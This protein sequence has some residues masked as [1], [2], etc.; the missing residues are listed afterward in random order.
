[1]MQRVA[2]CPSSAPENSGAA[3]SNRIQLYKSRL[4]SSCSRLFSFPAR[5][6]RKYTI[7]A[8][9]LLLLSAPEAAWAACSTLG[10]TVTCTPGT[11][12]TT[13][14]GNGDPSDNITVNV[15]D[16][17]QISVGN[18]N[19]I[20]LGDNAVINLGVNSRVLNNASG[21]SGNGRWNAG[22][23][24]IEFGSYGQ[25]TIGTGAVVAANGTS[26]NGEP[27]NVMG[28]GNVITNY[29]TV[30]SRSGAAIWFEDRTAGAGNTVDNYGVIE[31][32]LGANANVIGNQAV[33]NVTF[34]NRTGATVRGSLSFA[35]GNDT[36]ILETGSVITGSFNGGGGTNTLSL[37]GAGNDSLAG[38]IRNFQTLTKDGTGRWTLTGAIGANGGNAAL[39]VFVNQGTLALTGNNANFNGSVTVNSAGTLEARAQSLPPSILDNGLVRFA[40]D[41]AG[42]YSGVISGTGAVEKALGGTL[43]LSGTNSY[44]GGTTINSGTVLISTDA[45]LGAASGGLVL[46]GG[47]LGVTADVATARATTV[48]PLGG[49]LNAAGGTTLTHNG[50][51]SGPGVLSKGDAGTVVLTGT[52]SYAGGTV[53]NAGTLQVSQDANLGATS[54][55]IGFAGGTLRTTADMATARAGLVSASGGTVETLAGTTLTYNGM[56]A[57]PGTLTKTGGGTMVLTAANAHGGTAI[58]GGVVQISSD[59]N[60]GTAG[61]AVSFDNGTLRTTQGMTIARPGTL[62]AGGG[63]IEV[64]GNPTLAADSVTITGALTGSGG[65]TKTGSG[66][67][68]LTGNNSYAGPTNVTSGYLFVNGDQ[69]GATG[70]T[71]ASGANTRLS[72]GGTIGGD[73][74]ITGGALLAP[75]AEFGQAGTLTIGGDLNLSGDSVLF[76]NMVDTSVGGPLNDLTVVNGDLVLDGR[77]NV[78]DQGQNLGPGVYRIINYA[79]AL[80]NNGLDIGAFTDSNGTTT[81]ALS[82]FSVQTVVP[83]QVNL[84]NT[85]GLSLNY[86][87]GSP[88]A[89]KNNNVIEGGDG[90]WYHAGPDALAS[91]TDPTGAVN[92]PWADGQFAIFIGAPG[93]VTASNADGQITVSGM[94]FGVNGYLLQGDPLLLVGST[95]TPGESTIRVGD[96]TGAGGAMTAEI[97]A[98]LTG[99]TLLRKTDAGTLVLSGANSYTGGT[100]IEG[101]VVQIASDA[102]LGAAGTGLTLQ[103]GV[104]RTTA[105]IGS[106]RAVTLS[107]GG[108]TFDTLAGTTLSLGS[109][110][111]GAGALTKIGDGNLTLLADSSY[112]GG[113]TI[114]AGTLQLGNGGTTG[115]ITGPIIDNGTLLVNRSNQLVLDGVIVGAGSLVQAGTGTT[116]LAADNLFT[117]T[118]TISAGTLQLGNGGTT[119]TVAGPIVDNAALVINR[120]ND[121]TLASA[122]S[123]TGTLTHTGTGRTILTGAN[124]YAGATTV[125]SGRLYIDGNQSA[126]TGTSTAMS[127]TRL[128]GSGIIGGDVVIQDGATLSPGS[129]SL[130]PGT[131]TING[132]LTLAPNS[133]MLYNIMNTVV[134]G[135]GNDLTVVGGDLVLDG[136]VNIVDQGQTLGPGVYRLFNYGGALTDNG[137]NIGGYTADGS[138]ITRPLTDFIVQTVI[139]NQVNLINTSGHDLNY[140][141]GSAVANKNDNLIQGGDGTWYAAGPLSTNAWT[142]PAGSINAPWADG[143]FAIFLGAPGTVRVSMDDGE[144]RSSG[145][146]FGVDGYVLVPDEAG[147]TLTLVS[148]PDG[149]GT[150]TLRVGDGTA[151]GAGMTATIDVPLIGDV[152]VRKTDA[153]TLILNGV[154][155]YTGGTRIEGGVVQIATDTA[156]GVPTSQLT[157]D[158]GTLRMTSSLDKTRQITLGPNGGTF[159]TAS[160][161]VTTIHTG[162]EG[163]GSLGK[164]GDGT[165]VLV[166]DNTYTGG[167]VISAGTL[168]IGNGGTTGHINGDIVNNATLVINRSDTKLTPGVISGTGQLIQ[169]GTGTTVLQANNTYTGGTIISAGTLQ[170][171]DG[172]TTGH[173]IGDILNNSILVINRSDT[174]LTPAL[175]SGTGQLIQAGTGTTCSRPTIPI[176]AAPRSMQARCRSAMAVRPAASSATCSTTA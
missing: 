130:V 165:L 120:S 105:D 93:T 7:A 153:G 155:T 166:N 14:V 81:R 142:D 115:S 26:N 123:G 24:T 80:T 16:N 102:N 103:S 97:A 87:D 73:V 121:F 157:L 173:V 67:L 139:P 52:N 5:S 98:P 112:S 4:Q 92:A 55:V 172:G 110:V 88:P 91:W 46:N 138:T 34:Y 17:A 94:Q 35:G 125:Q 90:I 95:D 53:I 99:S 135:A 28:T 96:G 148:A 78:L 64:G 134:G 40:Q 29:G 174:K 141:D 104:L 27:I 19:A 131:L 58:N 38:D 50:T 49:G 156:L 132:N 169:A 48:G 1:M 30:T 20:S 18:D 128:G 60:L 162:V 22:P 31:T 149:S 13:R 108:G 160:G 84:I 41:T 83:G 126:A 113:T 61:A 12:Q 79:G 39:Q 3:Q 109:A 70:P 54:G 69:S 175:I 101:G 152:L 154:N 85:T 158:G 146:Q 111:T 163:P 51:I 77:I 86:W 11:T 36:L 144:I 124:S 44:S 133:S 33:S 127:G 167:T 176:R 118:S 23:N 56:L 21:S 62:N 168:Q 159:D 137:L 43:T 63:T 171:G 143:Q 119:G 6:V 170:I 71:T 106:A 116:I 25:L 74:S 122:I 82:G 66:R 76:Y 32:L 68:V 107:T 9:G 100:R 65:M 75:G 114:R 15:Q 136:T 147:D 8:T 89:N 150:A 57:G 37:S 140:W 72:G 164:A 10:N 129:D 42:D 45:N 145:M 2:P 59:A 151:A 117:G 161:T 47:T